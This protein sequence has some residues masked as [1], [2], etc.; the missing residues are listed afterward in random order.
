MESVPRVL[1]LL[2]AETPEGH[3]R[4][5]DLL[6]AHCG[7]RCKRVFLG[8]GRAA[9]GS[10]ACAAQLSTPAAWT[11]LA[12]PRLLRWLGR[13]PASIGLL[14]AWSAPAARLAAALARDGYRA[15][16]EVLPERPAADSLVWPATGRMEDVPHYVCVSDAQRTELERAGAPP[17]RC[18]VMG[19]LLGRHGRLGAAFPMEGDVQAAMPRERGAVRERLRLAEGDVAVLVAPPVTRASGGFVAAWAAMLAEKMHPAVRCIVPAGGRETERIGRLVESCRHERMFR[20]AHPEL[21]WEQL[22]AAADVCA[23]LAPGPA[24][25]GGAALAAAAGCPLVAARVPGHAE[26]ADEATARLCRPNDPASAARALWGA[27]EDVEGT[28]ARAE[29]ARERVQERWAPP[30]V[31]A[32]Y[33]ALYEEI[34]STLAPAG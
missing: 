5:C 25:L 3:V 6:S 18:R 21:S 26:L 28:R 17:E 9:I 2:T 32:R 34:G 14:H 33:E 23:F 31:L 19:P 10:L 27:I 29:R 12:R 8:T 22:T 1:H 20:F 15:V 24:A 30:A 7:V 11:A 4:T 16:I 13:H